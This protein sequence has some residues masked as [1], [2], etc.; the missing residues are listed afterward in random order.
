MDLNNLEEHFANVKID[1][2]ELV[3]FFNKVLDFHQDDENKEKVEVL[4]KQCLSLLF[5]LKQ[6]EQIQW[7]DFQY[8]L[9]S[10]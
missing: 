10:Q 3:T 4:M 6:K 9:Q 7:K 8:Y 1:I 5:H 2:L